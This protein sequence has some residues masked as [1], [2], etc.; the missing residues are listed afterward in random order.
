MGIRI[1]VDAHH[2]QLLAGDGR[3]RAGIRN[4]ATGAE[5]Q[6]TEGRGQGIEDVRSH[7]V[8]SG[9]MSTPTTSDF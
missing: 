8:R 5:S 1:G 9:P 3:G 2:L 7:L 6:Q 4:A